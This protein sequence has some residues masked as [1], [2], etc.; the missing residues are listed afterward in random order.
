[1]YMDTNG[2]TLSGQTEFLHMSKSA[3]FIKGFPKAQGTASH[4]KADWLFGVWRFIVSIRFPW[5]H[6]Q[7][8]QSLETQADPMIL[9]ILSGHCY[10][11]WGKAQNEKLQLISL[12]AQLRNVLFLASKCMHKGNP[13]YNRVQ[14]HKCWATDPW[15]TLF[16]LTYWFNNSMFLHYEGKVLHGFIKN[17]RVTVWKNVSHFQ[18][19][20]WNQL[21]IFHWMTFGSLVS[22]YE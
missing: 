18:G 12:A 5:N 13:L 20:S 3:M 8:W 6:F 1:M 14:T 11:Q 21:L 4:L 9:P 10:W 19:S 17:V 22:Y 2:W 15:Q 7:T 16:W